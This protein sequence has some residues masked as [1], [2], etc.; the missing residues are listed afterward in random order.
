MYPNLWSW[1]QLKIDFL[2]VWEVK[3]WLINSGRGCNFK[4]RYKWHCAS[5][6]GGRR[7]G[8]WYNNPFQQILTAFFILQQCR[9]C[10]GK[11]GLVSIKGDNAWTALWVMRSCSVWL[12]GPHWLINRGRERETSVYRSATHWLWSLPVHNHYTLTLSTA[13]AIMSQGEGQGHK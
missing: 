4:W 6:S 12:S 11:R 9:R 1:R 10:Q 13:T 8:I 7:R 3:K 5:R 2:S